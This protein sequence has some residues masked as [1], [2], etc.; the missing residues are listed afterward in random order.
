MNVKRIFLILLGFIPL[1]LGFLMNYWMMKYQDSVLP[2]T[3]TGIIFLVLWAFIGFLTCE[4]EETPSKS[5][6]IIHSVAFMMLLLFVFQSFILRQFW[7]NI[8]GIISQFYFL[9]LFSISG[10]I[11]NLILFMF[12]TSFVSLDAIISFL[13]MIGSYKLGTKFKFLD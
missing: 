11:Q 13:L 2:Y 6:K 3:L 10:S 1:A 9:P 8:V 5:S 4:F 7:P 12:R